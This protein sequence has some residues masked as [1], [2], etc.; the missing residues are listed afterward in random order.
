MLSLSELLK[1]G[2]KN[3]SGLDEAVLQNIKAVKDLAKIILSSF[4][5]NGLN[6][7]II[8]HLSKL[9]VTSDAAT[10]I[11]E[12]DVVHPAAK[13]A[14]LA[15]QMQEQ[16]IGDGTNLVVSF[17]GELLQNAEALVQKGLHPSE[18]VVG[19]SKALEEAI[20]IMTESL[21][22]SKI[23]NMNDVPAVTRCLKSVVAAKLYGYE[24]M[25]APLITKACLN[26]LPKNP[27]NFNVDNVRVAK[28]LGG[29]ILD[30]QVIKGHVLTRDSEGTIKHIT[31]A[32]V[33]V[34]TGG[35]DISKT[36]TKDTVL[37][38]TADELVN[39]NKSEEA[40]MEQIIRE[41][42]ESGAKVVVAGASV[43]EM[44]LHFLER[45][46]LMVVKVPSK[47]E[48]RRIAKAVNATPLARLGGPSAEEL[49]YCDIVT[50]EEIGSTK[51]TIF[52]QEKEEYGQISTLVVRAST[53]NLLDDIER[54]IDDG[55]NVF[56]AMAKDGR[57]VA[58]AGA[59]EI[60]LARRL[61][62]V[63]DSTP[64]LIQYA[65]KKF[66]ESFEVVP[67]TLA[68]NV[69]FKSTDVLSNLYASHQKGNTGDG[70]D[71]EGT[72]V[73]IKN[74]VEAGIIDLLSTKLSAIK[75]ATD[76]AVTILRVDQI[77]MAKPAGGPKPP[78]Q[79]SVDAED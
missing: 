9:F 53:Q 43:G 75:L 10:I 46:K 49:G 1:E 31:N 64:G 68:E 66:G 30:T 55:V 65:I 5:P 54:S 4:G 47:F 3:I 17:C 37:I 12:L 52:R 39:Y 79:G 40:A 21:V 18:I 76:A 15:S 35:I 62:Q 78:K 51:V 71:V 72:D 8:N 59:T 50:V 60:E 73:Q 13:M 16:E 67:R 32:K 41:I 26:V 63:A 42:S 25:L 48:L 2:S 69:G 61:Q 74:A 70:V 58:G 19:Y 27:L 14:V 56:K 22:V 24:D 45:Y 33:A 38:K 7:M 36:E 11:K 34:F 29:G 57:F 77:I 6:K 23:D 20:K 28:I 44:A